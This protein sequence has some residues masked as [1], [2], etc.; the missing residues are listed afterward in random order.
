MFVCV[1]MCVCVCVC[2]ITA[3]QLVCNQN[4]PAT[5]LSSVVCVCIV[6]L[7]WNVEET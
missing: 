6:V 5:G 7:E 1:C 2:V 3:C 4:P